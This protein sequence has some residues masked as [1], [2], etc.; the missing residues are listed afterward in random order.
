MQQTAVSDDFH[1]SECKLQVPPPQALFQEIFEICILSKSPQVSLI[2]KGRAESLDQNLK[3]T[4]LEH[5]VSIGSYQED[6]A[7][8]RYCSQSSDVGPTLG[9]LTLL[10]KGLHISGHRC[11]ESWA[12]AFKILRHE[13]SV[14]SVPETEQTLRYM[15]SFSGIGRGRGIWDQCLVMVLI[16]VI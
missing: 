4:D 16:C 15:L 10:S 13:G 2:Q 3:N 7:S 11:P 9:Y 1:L 12:V 14:R 8:L 6:G 5:Q